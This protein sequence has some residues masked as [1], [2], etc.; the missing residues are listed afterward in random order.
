MNIHILF[1]I[2]YRTDHPC[3]FD[4]K[5]QTFFARGCFSV[6]LHSVNAL[7]AKQNQVG[8]NLHREAYYH[9]DVKIYHHV[10]KELREDEIVPAIESTVEVMVANAEPELRILL[11][12]RE[13]TFNMEALAAFKRT[14]PL[15]K[16]FIKKIAVIGIHE[17]QNAFLNYISNIFKLN[18]RAFEDV[19]K[20][21]DWLIE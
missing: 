5:R 9:R 15:S 14:S 2:H 6:R 12:T 8:L 10:Y 17:I 11:D 3:P 20:A 7:H 19:D 21:R 4:N 1:S 16:P 18:I 13:T